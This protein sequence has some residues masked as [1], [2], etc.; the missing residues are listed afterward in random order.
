[1]FNNFT[2]QQKLT[3]CHKTVKYKLAYVANVIRYDDAYIELAD[4]FV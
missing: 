1:L 3:V 2:S 4:E